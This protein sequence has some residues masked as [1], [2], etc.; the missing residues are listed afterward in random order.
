MRYYDRQIDLLD[1][2]DLFI[3]YNS[4]PRNGRTIHVDEETIESY[5]DKLNISLA[6]AYE[7]FLCDRGVLK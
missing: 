5:V 3:H 4:S 1:N 6:E 2:G 7:L